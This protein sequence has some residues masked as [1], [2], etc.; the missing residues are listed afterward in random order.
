MIEAL[1][2]IEVNKC[3]S[4]MESRSQPEQYKTAVW[5]IA[6][7]LPV[8]PHPVVAAISLKKN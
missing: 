1:S 2:N 5:Y 4:S 3:Q 8:M 7:T 6:R